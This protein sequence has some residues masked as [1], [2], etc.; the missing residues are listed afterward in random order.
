MVGLGK[1]IWPNVDIDDGQLPSLLSSLLLYTDIMNYRDAVTDL[2]IVLFDTIRSDPKT[3]HGREGFYFSENG[4]HTLYEVGKAIAQA[5]VEVGKSTSAE[6]T[7]FTDEEVKK[8]FGVS[9][10]SYLLLCRAFRDNQL[11]SASTICPL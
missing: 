11:I 1:N 6:P 9:H 8:Y 10:D 5:L 2:Y 7:T 3:P 4:E